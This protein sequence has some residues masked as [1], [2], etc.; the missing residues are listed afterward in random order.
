METKSAE[1]R[2]ILQL[3]KRERPVSSPVS[4]TLYSVEVMKNG[5]KWAKGELD[6]MILLRTANKQVLLTSFHRGT[7]ISSFQSKASI[8]FKVVEGSLE[9]HSE[10]ENV[11]LAKGQILTVD[12]KIEYTLRT[13]DDTIFLLT[14][15]ND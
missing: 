3:T 6:T 13:M 5:L 10:I 12:D 7:E 14:I 8:T 11:V 1:T 9:F 15:S 2:K 4:S